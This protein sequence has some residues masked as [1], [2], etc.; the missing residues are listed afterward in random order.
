MRRVLAA[1]V[2]LSF[3][4]LHGHETAE[5]AQNNRGP[6]RCSSAQ[7]QLF[8]NDGRYESA[9]REF[10]CVIEAAPTEVEGYRGRIEAELLLGLFSDAVEDYGRLTAKVLPSHPDALSIILAGYDARLALNPDEIPALTGSSFAQWYF[11]AYASAVHTLN[12][13]LEVRPL[14]LYG[15]L[16]SGSSR[17]LLG[18]TRDRGEADLA[19]A[20]ALAPTS[21]DVRFIV[22]DAYTYGL[23]EPVRAFTEATLAMHLGLNTARIHAILASAYKAFGDD[24]NAAAH[25]KVHI[26]LV[27]AEFVPTAPL[28]PRSTFSLN[29]VPGRTFEIPLVVSTGDVLSIVTGSHDFT[30][31]ILVLLAPDGTPVLG[32]DDDKQYFAAF[33]A[34]A[35]ET[36]T[37]LMQVTSFESVGTGTLNVM[38]K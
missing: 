1:C 2:V 10:T 34:V 33:E 22:A 35:G 24:L 32:S 4:L 6:K 19:I 30:D 9:I 36:G 13:L 20:I 5:A 12:H 29:L 23:S 37:Y 21:P 18:A 27:T 15:N 16:F 25:I 17:L 14:D 11:F 3:V 38:R 28:P 8:I 7:G 26:D 31:T